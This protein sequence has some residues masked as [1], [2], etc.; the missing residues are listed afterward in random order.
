M[1]KLLGGRGRF[2]T[3]VA[4]ADDARRGGW[5]FWHGMVQ[6]ASTPPGHKAGQGAN[7]G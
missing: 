5:L 2:E 7:R 3:V 6:A 1:Q 4:A